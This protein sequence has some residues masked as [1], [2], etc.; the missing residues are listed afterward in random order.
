MALKRNMTMNPNAPQANSSNSF[1]KVN[2]QFQGVQVVDN[3][4]FE[5]V[6][7][8]REGEKMTMFFKVTNLDSEDRNLKLKARET[9]FYTNEGDQV[10][11]YSFCIANNCTNYNRFY[12]T[13]K[14]DAVNLMP[15]GIPLKVKLVLPKVS[16]ESTSFVRGTFHLN[17]TS[18]FQM[19]NIEFPKTTLG[20]NT[21]VY[22][23]FVV[24]W[25]S[26]IKEDTGTF[27]YFKVSNQSNNTGT[28]TLGNIV[29]YDDQGNQYNIAKAAFG[30][31]ANPLSSQKEILA[32]SIENFYIPV[33]GIN[34]EAT[35]IMRVNLNIG[36][37]TYDFTEALVIR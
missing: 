23:D 19:F 25:E 29:A 37:S 34:K 2:N 9:T 20:S 15:S 14:G 31:L 26:V 5:F 6:E 21:V 36:N 8:K 3:F 27:L 28:F 33:K 11:G 7:L 22:G 13:F 24:K 1:S 12:G 10:N 32:G 35:S 18:T 16:K 4:K 30:E 17:Q